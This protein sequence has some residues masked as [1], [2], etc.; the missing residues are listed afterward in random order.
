MLDL[1]DSV[2]PKSDQINADD[3]ITGPRTFTVTEVRKTGNEEQ[4][5]AIYLAEFP[6]SRPYKPN[7]SMLRVLIDCW[8][9]DGEV[10]AG[11][12]FTLYRDPSV[13]F[14]KDNPGG[15]RISHVSHIDGPR[16][17]NLTVT[18]G[19]RAPY[20]VDPLPADAPSSPPVSEEE[21]ARIA[22]LRAEWKTADP[23]RQAEIQAEVA[24]LQGGAA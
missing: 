20:A 6:R 17:V 21:V 23:E 18:R 24:R 12:R 14:G 7:K 8:G 5:V 11:R 9:P 15:I 10:F 13:R 2:V 3:L 16:K 22:D 19:K 1:T 4:P